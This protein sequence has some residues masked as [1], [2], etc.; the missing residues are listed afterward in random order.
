[1]LLGTG[2]KEILPLLLSRQAGFG[3]AAELVALSLPW[4]LMFALPIG[5]LTATLL[6]FGRFSA[7]QELT[8][9]RA[10]GISLLSLS[11]PI[12]ALSLVG[13]LLCAALTLEISPRSRVAMKALK[14]AATGKF[15]DAFLPAGQAITKFPGKLIY[16][17]KN[18]GE[19]LNEI[20]I[21][22]LTGS[23]ITEQVYA[24]RGTYA[25][26]MAKQEI[27]MR[28]FNMQVLKKIGDAYSA[29]WKFAGEANYRYSLVDA[30]KRGDTVRVSD[31]TFA[32]ARRELIALEL[33]THLPDWTPN[34]NPNATP[35]ER[36]HQR[37]LI[38]APLRLQ[39]H[40]Q[41]AFS[42]AC[43][44]FTLIGIPLAIRVHRRETNIGIALAL[45]LVALYYALL[46]L[47][48]SMDSKPQLHPEI[49]MWVPNFL[50]QAVGGVLLWRANKN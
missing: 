17:G 47:A 28:L 9:A 11:A 23:N 6:V 22:S 49:L 16:I 37:A 34:A 5:M 48:N 19:N 43:F 21:Y 32:Q 7:E 40:Q 20:Y 45:G 31:M 26:D 4:V 29:E 1:F 46:L 42:F 3:V 35:A 24:P 15:A 10:S 18:D 50:F 14:R 27:F 12:I 44:G 33:Q 30:L 36:A 38:T 39:L 8:A 13:C 25:A 2:L 41:L